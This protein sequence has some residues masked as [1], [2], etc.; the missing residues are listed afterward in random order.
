M[1]SKLI[2]IVSP[3][4]NESD[5]VSELYRR[6]KDSISTLNN[7][8]FEL[9]FID[10]AS[11]DDTV[12]KLKSLARV[13]RTVKIIVNTRNF[14]HIRSPYYGI[15]QSRGDAT[16]YLASD[17]QDPPEI[18]PQFIKE[19]ESGYKLVMAIKPN[20]VGSKFFHAIRSSYYRVLNFISDIELLENST[21]FGLYDNE[22]LSLLRAINDPYPYLRGIICE[23]G[24]KIKKIEFVQPTRKRGISKNNLYT[25]Y[26]I[27]IL[28]IVNHSKIPLRIA[29]MFGF[30][31]GC[32]CLLVALIYLFQKLFYWNSFGIGIAPIVIG[33]FFMMGLI[34]IFLGLLGEYVLVIHNKILN[35]PIV[36][37]KER[38][39]FD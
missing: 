6:I 10:N 23:L 11:T 28:G 8:D 24:Y 19:W 2:S 30:I 3:C 32:I 29:T 26:D 25:L 4:F 13:D 16:I 37:E 17:L 18:I 22:V 35:K 5:N 36:V 39:N 33:L 27:G 34:F 1:A 12:D 20:V 7:Y 14:G 15:L 21:G 38:I 31:T 9:I